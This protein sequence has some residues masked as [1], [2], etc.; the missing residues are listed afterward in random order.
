M[1]RTQRPNFT[2]ANGESGEFSVYNMSWASTA[3]SLVS[4]AEDLDRFGR[5]LLGGRLLRPAE[6]AQLKEGGFGFSQHEVGGCLV[7]S[8]AGAVIGM[9]AILLASE[10]GRRTFVYES[11]TQDFRPGPQR[12]WDRRS[13]PS[14]RPPAMRACARDPVLT[15]PS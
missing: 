8:T 11:N 10:D 2:I 4:T 5:A 15:R 9:D 14:S 13:T 6:L 7:W 1:V 12:R 3:G